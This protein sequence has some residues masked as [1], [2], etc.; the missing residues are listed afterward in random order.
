MA[1]TQSLGVTKN[2]SIKINKMYIKKVGLLLMSFI[3]FSNFLFGQTHIDSIVSKEAQQYL[4]NKG[5]IGL[6]IGVI[7]N[8]QNFTYNYGLSK[9]IDTKPPTE[10]SIYSIGSISKTFVSILLGKI[11]HIDHPRSFS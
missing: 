11:G 10:H 7:F 5:T 9:L 2:I 6:S 3:Y 1:F 4:T 8:N